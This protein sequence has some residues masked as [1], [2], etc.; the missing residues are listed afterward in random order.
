MNLHL[1]SIDEQIQTCLDTIKQL[2]FKESTIK[3]HQR[4]LL[5]LKDFV[6]SSGQ[7]SYDENIGEKYQFDLFSEGTTKD[8]KLREIRHTINLLNDII[9]QVPVRKKRVSL[10]VYPLPGDFGQHIE[11]FLE[12]VR[13][14]S[15]PKDNT[16]RNYRAALSHFAIRMQQDRIRLDTLDQMAVS[17]FIS[18]LQNTQLRVC[19][20]VRR[21]LRYLFENDNVKTDYSIPLYDIKCHRAEKL[22]SIYNNEEIRKME[23]S[24]ERSSP[25]GRRNYA[26][27]LLASRLG[28][29]AS[30]IRFLQFNELDWDKNVINLIQCKTKK[31]IELPLLNIVGEAIIDYIQ[32]GRP[33]S[34]SKTIFLTA[35]APYTTISV[36]GIS[37][38]VSNI[39]YKAGIGT[40]NRH[41][42]SHCLRHS[43]A[44]RLLRQGTTLPVISDVLG[45]SDSQTTM[46]YLNVDINGLLQCSLDAPPVTD[47]FY[48]QK[49]GWFYE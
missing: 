20:P 24:M 36:P 23:A 11:S 3:R 32:N 43:L 38:I 26:I 22:P 8:Y 21:F 6:R 27:F 49:G 33:K 17:R 9:N 15:R 25:T 5:H 12:Q 1:V 41:R 2:D 35:N 14:E 28:L 48:M 45:H 39:I 37:S 42:G 13:I 44:T 34:H 16:M 30:D 19:V 29:R 4:H 10:K 47:H 46:V 18:S 40:K 31:M 7:N